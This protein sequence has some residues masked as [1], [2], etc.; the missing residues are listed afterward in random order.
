MFLDGVGFGGVG[1]MLGL[2]VIDT[3]GIAHYGKI[4][5]MIQMG[6]AIP[7][8][9]APILGGYVYDTTGSYRIHFG[10]TTPVFALALVLLAS[11][12]PA[13]SGAVRK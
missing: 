13:I 12:K 6:V 7:S 5:G 11:G 8:I 2:I 3:F 4:Q 1:A 10:I 9:T